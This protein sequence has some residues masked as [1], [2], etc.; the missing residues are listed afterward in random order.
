MFGLNRR[1]KGKK[2]NKRGQ[3]SRAVRAKE[4]LNTLLCVTLLKSSSS[5][6]ME[7]EA[8]NNPVGLA[9][10]FALPR[11]QFYRPPKMVY[12]NPPGEM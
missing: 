9:A 7:R 4:E 12:L 2:A 5:A 10:L 1:K 11:F 3:Q 6:S 8:A